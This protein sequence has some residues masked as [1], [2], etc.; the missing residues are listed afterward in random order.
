LI[1]PLRSGRFAIIDR[2]DYQLAAILD[3][4][5]TAAELLDFSKAQSQKMGLLRMLTS[6]ARFLGEPSDQ[7]WKRDVLRARRAETVHRSTNRIIQPRSVGVAFD[8]G[9]E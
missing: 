3:T 2:S 5:P 9:E 1:L 6:E 8:L 7:D 4:A